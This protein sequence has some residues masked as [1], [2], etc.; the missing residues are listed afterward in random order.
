M[1]RSVPTLAAVSRMRSAASTAISRGADSSAFSALTKVT[2]TS[3]RCADSSVRDSSLVDS[4]ALLLPV[5]SKEKRS[6]WI[7][8]NRTSSPGQRGTRR[9][10]GAVHADPA[11]RHDQAQD[12]DGAQDGDRGPG[13]PLLI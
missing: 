5:T 11:R 12:G 7:I 10:D 4:V 2:S 9:N 6:A 3:L 1:R 13:Q 8:S